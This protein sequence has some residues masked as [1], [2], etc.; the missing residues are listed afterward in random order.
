MIETKSDLKQAILNQLNKEK[1]KAIPGKLLAQRLGLKD[2]RPIREAH[3]EILSDGIPMIGTP[4]DGYWIADNI[5][6]CNEQCETLMKY[7]KAYGY[8]YKLLR[9]ASRKLSGQI[10]MRLG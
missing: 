4:K 3:L 8:H 6:D 7:L 10:K 2:T 5:E 9:N 1:N